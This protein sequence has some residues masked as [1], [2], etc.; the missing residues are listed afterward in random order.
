MT[1]AQ[2]TTQESSVLVAQQQQTQGPMTPWQQLT[3]TSS[4]SNNGLDTSHDGAMMEP[5]SVV[6]SVKG[7]DDN[8]VDLDM[9]NEMVF[10][11]LLDLRELQHHHHQQQQQCYQQQLPFDQQ[12]HHLQQQP[13]LFLPEQQMQAEQTYW[14]MNQ[15]GHHHHVQMPM[16]VVKSE[17]MDELLEEGLRRYG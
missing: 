17:S 11:Y 9:V 12:S 6:S 13:L 5:S 4:G 1:P 10:Q 16:Y 2:F 7:E 15:H 3:V 14:T 8:E